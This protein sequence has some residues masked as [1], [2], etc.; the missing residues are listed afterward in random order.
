MRVE[1]IAIGDELLDGRV[2]DRN[3]AYLASEL[4]A[5]GMALSRITV[6]SD[7]Q[8]EIVAELEAAS[9]RSDLVVC[10]GGLGPTED[11]RTRHAAAAWMGEELVFSEEAFR[12]IEAK[13]ES[14]GIQITPNNRQQAYFPAG[15]EVLDN[16]MGTAPA[17]CCTKPGGFKAFFLPGVPREYKWLLE[18]YAFE[19]ISRGQVGAL[20]R[21]TRKFFGKGESALEHELADIEFPSHVT[22]GYRAHFPEIHV[23]ISARAASEEEARSAVDDVFA[24]IMARIGRF[25]VASGKETVAERVGRLLDEKG[26]TVTCAE[27]CTGGM[28]AASL[29]SIPGSSSYFR[30]SFVTYSNEAKEKHVGVRRETLDAHGAVSPEV[31]VEMA[32]GALQAA[33]ADYSMAISGIAG[34][35][36][37]SEEK[38]VGTVDVAV[39]SPEGVYRVRLALRAYW[40]RE[41]IRKASTHHALALLLKV[42]EGRVEDDPRVEGPL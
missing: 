29:V 13:F 24:Q 3:G 33:S 9:K 25:F 28:V 6:V 23:T 42:L 17:F 5:R 16:Q 36:G 37:G 34:P 11:D 1:V 32:Q 20:V 26:A 41:R 4:R 30:E 40:G 31:V 10:S 12:G 22:V 14:F 39:G 7:L 8:E 15:A 21:E 38:P 27:S 2:L 18:T 19:E 35:G